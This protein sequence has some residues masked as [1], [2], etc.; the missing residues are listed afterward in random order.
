MQV[1]VIM[2][3]LCER[4]KREVY[5]V[6][7]CNYCGRKIGVECVKSSQRASKISRLVICK[8]DW[9]N[10]KKRTIYKN[11]GAKATATAQETA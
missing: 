3:L 4:C 7:V 9:S 6:E 10:I 11:K 5:R 1:G 2:P 8:D